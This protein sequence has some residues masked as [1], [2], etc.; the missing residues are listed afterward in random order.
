M[1]KS[2]AMSRIRLEE[3]AGLP[4]YVLLDKERNPVNKVFDEQAE[5]KESS[6]IQNQLKEGNTLLCE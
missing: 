6:R 2:Q 5:K 3:R 1:I 4:L